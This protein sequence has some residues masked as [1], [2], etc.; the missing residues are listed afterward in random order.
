[1]SIHF[2]FDPAKSASNQTKHGIDIIEAQTLWQGEHV[3]LP[4]NV[5][6]GEIRYII[7]GTING[8]HHAAIFTYR[9]AI[10]RI[11]SA[12]RASRKERAFYEQQTQ[13]P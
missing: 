6:G 1:M 8:V 5:A 7:F 4:A 10:V 9:G 3:V 13:K 2:E 12:R 11:I